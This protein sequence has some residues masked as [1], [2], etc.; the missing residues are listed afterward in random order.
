MQTY[1]R[2]LPLDECIG[3]RYRVQGVLGEGGFGITYRAWDEKLKRP[4]VI[5]EYLPGELGVRD[6]ASLS[7]LP[8]SNHEADYR[9]GL[10]K[11]LEEAVT[12]ARFNHPHI[13]PILDHLEANGTAYIVMKFEE[14]ETLAQR[15]KRNKSPWSE[16]ALLDL[17][18]PILRG[19]QQVHQAGL[20]HRDIKPGNLFLRKTGGPLLI[21]FGSARHA[22]GE[23]SKSLS[24]IVSLGYAPPE[25]YSTRGKQ[26]PWTDLYGLG[27]VLYELISGQTPV[28]SISRSH[29]LADDEPD[30]LTPAIRV[31]QDKYPAWLLQLTD[32]L[33]A[34]KAKERPQSCDEVLQTI[35]QRALSDPATIQITPVIP[36]TRLIDEAERWDDPAAK[37]PQGTRRVAE[38]ERFP[39]KTRYWPWAILAL[40]SLTS[41]AAWLATQDAPVTRKE[42]SETQQ[43]KP[44]A[45]PPAAT[46]QATHRPP[47]A[48]PAKATPPAQPPIPLT[49]QLQLNVDAPNARVWLDG[50]EIGSAGP[51][52]PLNKEGITTGRHRIR[53]EAEG[54]QPWEG[55]AEI[56]RGQWQ[57][58]A[59]Q[60]KPEEEKA[61]REPTTGM[62]FKIKKME[63]EEI[64]TPIRFPPPTVEPLKPGV[65]FQDCDAC[66]RMVVIPAGRFTMGSSASD[67]ERSEAE[68]PQHEVII[69]RPFAVGKFEVTVDEWNAC[70]NEG[71]CDPLKFDRAGH[72]GKMPQTNASWHQAKKYVSWLTR[73]TGKSYR[74]PSEAEWEYAARAG[75]TTPYAF[76]LRSY[77]L[78]RDRVEPEHEQL[79]EHANGADRSAAGLSA[80]KKN[81]HCD[82][83]FATTAP[84]GSFP[85]NGFGLHDMAGN[86]WEWVED[87]W[88]ESY[89]EWRSTNKP[90]TDGSAWVEYKIDDLNSWAEV[91]NCFVRRKQEKKVYFVHQKAVM[92]GGSWATIPRA[93]R[94]TFRAGIKSDYR[95]DDAGFRM[96][97][98]LE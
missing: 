71:G 94:S 18:T 15:L 74:L 41:G 72:D 96:A 17:I 27:A 78:R 75:T 37:T 56:N 68:G 77:N 52:S 29:A 12:L 19:L 32:R 54:R 3:G 83:H 88:H 79:C 42:P 97:R 59:A 16:A 45:P 65:E 10:Q 4:I 33:L 57:Q 14:G 76:T 34:P 73:K 98:D 20:L 44:T 49:G 80:D 6:Q 91:R 36:K 5:K 9:F 85:A 89:D 81:Q 86:V 11:Y 7:V 63:K 58:I 47:A 13:V 40:V 66:P 50:S 23:H 21:D 93:L 1:N 64:A 8:R 90:P 92:R 43:T 28:E 62:E 53:I 70:L 48:E 25:Q 69:P 67:K 39:G 60:L 95:D 2:S 22:L 35:Q 84:V 38:S 24:A 30:P 61:Y 55:E 87:C 26:G 82:D 31:G 51:G 46:A